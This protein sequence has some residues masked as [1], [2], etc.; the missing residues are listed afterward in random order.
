[1][2]ALKNLRVNLKRLRLLRGLTQ[3][4]MAEKAGID[5]KYFQRVESGR[6]PGLQLGTIEKLARALGV[7]AW[8]LIAPT[9][10]RKKS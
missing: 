5:Y 4:A 9:A 10:K 7:E 6:W 3:Q 2:S 1:V 8:E